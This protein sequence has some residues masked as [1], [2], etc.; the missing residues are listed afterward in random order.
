MYYVPSATA[1][2]TGAPGAS[3]GSGTDSDDSCE[4]NN[5]CELGE[6]VEEVDA[7]ADDD[8]PCEG[9]A[10][11]SSPLLESLGGRSYGGKRGAGEGGE[12]IEV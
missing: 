11:F 4:L 8:T 2:S 3:D 1:D 9:G 6:E 5:P 7:D 12:T 10:S